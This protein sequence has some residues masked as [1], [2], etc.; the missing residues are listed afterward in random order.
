LPTSE[1]LVYAANPNFGGPASVRVVSDAGN[2]GPRGTNF[3]LSSGDPNILGTITY[4]TPESLNERIQR[5]VYSSETF[6][7]SI[8]S[9]EVK[10]D[11]L[12]TPTKLYISNNNIDNV[13]V[14]NVIKD[15]FLSV[16]EL[17]GSVTFNRKIPLQTTANPLDVFA[18]KIVS[19]PTQHSNYLS[20]DV[21]LS[22]KTETFIPTNG[23][24]L[25]ATFVD[26]P[27]LFDVC[28]NINPYDLGYLDL[29][30]YRN[31]V[32][33]GETGSKWY[34]DLAL[35]PGGFPLNITT[36]FNSSGNASYELED[37]PIPEEILPFVP[38]LTSENISI[39]F[40]IIG[41]NPT[42][43]NVSIDPVSGLVFDLVA[44]T[45][46]LTI[47]FSATKYVSG[48]WSPLT[49]DQK[50]HVIISLALAA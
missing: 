30:T 14:S 41:E 49:G 45:F 20:F 37:A 50:I 25:I 1:E 36:N 12:E 21:E 29:Y 27:K 7:G 47:D 11:S 34:N 24:E 31:P 38:L 10:F 9:G 19:Y 6:S 3:F 15:S 35:T 16:E 42:A 32:F 33:S 5:Y 46:N 17:K 48:T 22:F 43:S 40:S 23:E 26:R 39:Q 28:I 4:T 13:N 18:L 44:G 2:D 8:N